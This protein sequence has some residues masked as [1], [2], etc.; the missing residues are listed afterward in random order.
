MSMVKDGEVRVKHTRCDHCGREA[1][2]VKA[3]CRCASH[4]NEKRAAGGCR[5]KNAGEDLAK[6]HKRS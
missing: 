1:T 2:D 5:L 6:K 4:A 3:G